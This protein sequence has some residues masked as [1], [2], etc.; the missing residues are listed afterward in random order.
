MNDKEKSNVVDIGVW[1]RN[2]QLKDELRQI[3]A[4]RPIEVPESV[5]SEVVSLK[6]LARRRKMHV[7]DEIID[8]VPKAT[9]DGVTSTGPEFYYD[10]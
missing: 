5:K 6:A 9:D 7:V 3:E 2:K 4:N 1:Q 10:K 8:Q